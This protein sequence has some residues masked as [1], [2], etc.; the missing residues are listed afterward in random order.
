MG[1]EVLLVEG[2][3]IAANL[4][5]KYQKIMSLAKDWGNGV[6]PLTLVV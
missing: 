2:S 5:V 3:V 4:E 6:I 1:S